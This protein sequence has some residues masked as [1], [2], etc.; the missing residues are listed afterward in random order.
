MFTCLPDPDSPMKQRSL[1]VLFVLAFAAALGACSRCGAEGSDESNDDSAAHS[2]ALTPEEVTLAFAADLPDDLPGLLVLRDWDAVLA[3]YRALRPRIDAMIGSVGMVENDLRNT[4]GV[5]V[6]RSESLD[7]IGIASAS[8]VAITTI[9]NDPVVLL[10]LGDPDAFLAHIGEVVAGQPFNLRA[11]VEITEVADTTLHVY[12]RRAGDRARL[13]IAIRDDLAI[14]PPDARRAE[15]VL[16]VLGTAPDAPLSSNTAFTGALAEFDEWQLFGWIDATVIAN[17]IRRDNDIATLLGDHLVGRIE[18]MGTTAFGVRLAADR[19]RATA[20]TQLH[21]DLNERVQALMNLDGANPHFERLVGDDTY[22]FVRSTIEL[23]ALLALLH[24]E[25]GS[26]TSARIREALRVGSEQ[27]GMN[28]EDDVLPA[29]GPNLLVMA[30]RARMLTLRRVLTALSNQRMPAPGLVASGFGIVV[31]LQVSD[32]AT[33]D[34]MFEVI[35]P[36]LDGRAERYQDDGHTI[37]AFTDEDAD[38][39]NLVLTDE[40]LFL[41][42]QRNRDEL[43]GQLANGNGSLE[44]VDDEDAHDLVNAAAINGAF[45]DL[46]AVLEGPIGAVAAPTLPDELSDALANFDEVHVRAVPS[47]A[48]IRNDLTLVFTP[49]ADSEEAPEE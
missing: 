35:V 19:I 32:R 44:S 2:G 36:L 24:E 10:R 47:E 1:L 18:R 45:L 15:A 29:I 14:V 23:D 46:R 13:A 6:S 40:F 26:D 49:L 25:G 20:L 31:A 41:V 34:R 11:E 17:R 4:L 12:R 8:G 7:E 39:G 21:P 28:I 16:E 38:I 30:T 42:P 3:E 22:L 9:G 5:D 48:G 43:L 37:V 33:V 27:L